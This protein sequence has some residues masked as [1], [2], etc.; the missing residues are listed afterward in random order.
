MPTEAVGLFTCSCKS[1]Y[2]VNG[3][4]CTDT[5][6]CGDGTHICDPCRAMCTN[7]VGSYL[8]M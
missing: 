5:D 7:A 4:L 6:D 8:F 3:T 2:T 1:G